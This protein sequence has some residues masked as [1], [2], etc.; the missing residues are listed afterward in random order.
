MTSDHPNRPKKPSEQVGKAKLAGSRDKRRPNSDLKTDGRDQSSKTPGRAHAR[1]GP[2]PLRQ[3]FACPRISSSG[4]PATDAE[5]DRLPWAVK[6]S[7]LLFRSRP[8][9]HWPLPSAGLLWLL[10]AFSCE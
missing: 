6:W 4:G 3:L 1:N 2:D 7:G 9:Y 8:A 10:S 5:Q